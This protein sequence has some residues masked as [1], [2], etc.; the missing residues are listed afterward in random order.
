MSAP[1][2]AI[3][4]R[5]QTKVQTHP[6]G[7]TNVLP[8][9]VAQDPKLSLVRRTLAAASLD[10]LLFILTND[11]RT[12]IEFDR[13]SLITH[14]RG[15]SRL[16]ATNNEPEL[17][18]RTMFVKTQNAMAAALIDQHTSL[19]LSNGVDIEAWA[20][21]PIDAELK[22]AIRAYMKFSSLAR[23]LIIPLIHRRALV[24][25]LVLEFASKDRPS[26]PEI[27]AFMELAPMFAAAVAEKTLLASE[28]D[29]KKLLGAPS[30]H[31]MAQL[32]PKKYAVFA[33]VAALML[34]LTLFVIPFPFSLTGEAQV[35]PRTARMAFAGTDGLIDKVLVKEGQHVAQGETLAA[36]DPKELDLQ[37]MALSTQLD[38]LNHQMNR[39]LMEAAEKPSRLAEKTAA[40]LRREA[41]AAELK[42]L[43]W[44]KE[45]L[46]IRAPV[47]GIVVTKDVHT[48]AGKRLRTGE[49]FCEI[50]APDE[51]IAQVYVPEERIAEVNVGQD[52]DVYLNT[53]PAEAYPLKIDRIA[54][55]PDVLPRIGTVYRVS[56]PFGPAGHSLKVGLKG[57]AKVRLPKRTLWNMISYR[58][59]TRWNQLLLRL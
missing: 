36:M 30:S 24:G 47:S 42:F 5:I 28:P 9:L 31:H 33:A 39:I 21:L 6:T 20:D 38:M 26:D 4:R 1:Q 7:H 17:N 10:E 16:V 54:P 56:A 11:I 22:E 53:N 43:Q 25:H 15:T 14:V 44:K 3:T 46:E 23:V 58:L 48:L 41:A 29:V 18:K 12:L 49:V 50:A 52:V 40:A 59:A 37:I 19:L 45:Q 57:I 32:F 51:L 34:V 55:A 13:A 8:G 27:R 35:A 2:I